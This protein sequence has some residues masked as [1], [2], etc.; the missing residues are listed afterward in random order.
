MLITNN[1]FES[2][3]CLHIQ[4]NI[5]KFY[6]ILKGERFMM[7]GGGMKYHSLKGGRKSGVW[8]PGRHSISKSYGLDNSL[9]LE[10]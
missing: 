7:A 2:E 3:Y 6:Y 8:I 4:R 5:M 10:T 1:Q 9:S